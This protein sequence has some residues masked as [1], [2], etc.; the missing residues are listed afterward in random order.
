MKK[1][2]IGGKRFVVA[3]SSAPMTCAA[4]CDGP[5]PLPNRCSDGLKC[6]SC[7]AVC[8]PDDWGPDP[9]KSDVN[10]DDTPVMKCPGCRHESAQDI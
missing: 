5:L 1:P 3:G 2:C 10:G 7:G 9:Y 8:G 4:R 6:E